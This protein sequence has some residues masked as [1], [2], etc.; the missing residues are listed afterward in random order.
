MTKGRWHVYSHEK[1]GTPAFGGVKRENGEEPLQPRY[2]EG[3]R[4]LIWATVLSIVEGWEGSTSRS[5][6]RSQETCQISKPKV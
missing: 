6:A 4:K 2:C 1:F 5:E 3:L